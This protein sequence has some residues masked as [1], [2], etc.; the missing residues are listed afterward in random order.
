MET[1]ENSVST[2]PVVSGASNP[3]TLMAAIAYI[4]PLVIVSYL[5][6]KDDPFVKFHI[7][8]G[9]VLFVIEV[10]TWFLG[11][12]L[13]PLWFFLNII[14]LIALILSIVG[15]VRAVKGKEVRLPLV[16]KYADYFPI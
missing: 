6:D 15:I 4:G 8:Q 2:P 14:N 12:I 5:V 16:G 3:K 11:M 13:W 9:L 1:Q 10:A 7:K